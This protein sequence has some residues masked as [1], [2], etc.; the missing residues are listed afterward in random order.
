MEA[1]PKK[2]ATVSIMCPAPDDGYMAMARDWVCRSNSAI[3]IGACEL[4]EL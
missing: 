1:V 2:S 4:Q 3:Y